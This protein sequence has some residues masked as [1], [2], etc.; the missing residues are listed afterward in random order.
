MQTP[1]PLDANPIY[2]PPGCRPPVNRMT[3][4]YKNITF[5]QTSFAGGNKPKL[6]S[7]EVFLNFQSWHIGIFLLFKYEN[8]LEIDTNDIGF[9]S[10][11]PWQI[12]ICIQIRLVGKYFHLKFHKM[13]I[14]PT[15]V[16]SLWFASSRHF[17]KC[18]KLAIMA[19]I[20]FFVLSPVLSVLAILCRSGF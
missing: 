19:L 13:P 5:P 17:H 9:N 16:A 15:S 8:E 1:P 12:K 6:E 11:N 7:V 10:V 14:M 2:P 18:T 3:D 20:E 4:R